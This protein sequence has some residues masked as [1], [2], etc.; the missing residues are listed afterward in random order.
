[1]AGVDVPVPVP[2]HPAIIA[3]TAHDAATIVDRMGQPSRGKGLTA[4]DGDAHLGTE[5]EGGSL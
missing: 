3:L 1:M 4:R 5:A 2:E